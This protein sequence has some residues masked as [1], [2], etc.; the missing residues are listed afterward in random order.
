M[1]NFV[2]IEKFY[3]D[4]LELKNHI[5]YKK[6]LE[7]LDELSNIGLQYAEHVKIGKEYVILHDKNLER[8]MMSTHESEILTNQKFLD[9]CKGDVLVFGL[10]LGLI[11]FPL[12]NFKNVKSITIIEIDSDL[13]QSVGKLISTQDVDKKV[14]II[15]DN[16]FE[17]YKINKNFYD[18]IYF[19]IWAVIDK[20]AFDEMKTL[21]GLYYKFL[22]P[23]GWIDS[24]C[25]EE[26]LKIK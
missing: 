8:A 23:G 13:I 19:D 12:L 26:E 11:I 9:V 1:R 20:L 4:F 21:K 17:Y 3:P 24:W 16:A 2:E 7:S 15:N 22:K 10:G 18:V 25:S 14:N 5:I 6:K